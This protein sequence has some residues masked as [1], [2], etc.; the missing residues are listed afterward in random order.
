MG[1][2][3][4]FTVDFHSEMTPAQAK[5]LAGW[6]GMSMSF[7]GPLAELGLTRLDEDSGLFLLRGPGAG[8]WRLEARSYANPAPELV[9]DWHVEVANAA[10]ALDPTVAV[11]KR[12]PHAPERVI[13]PRPLAYAQ[14]RW[15]RRL[16]RRLLGL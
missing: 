3:T 13:A 9:H 14:T 16:V 15:P 8:K 2:T 4:L 10:R 6:L 1:A 5:R 7:N 12:R 11:P